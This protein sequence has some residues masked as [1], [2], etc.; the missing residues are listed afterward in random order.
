[1]QAVAAAALALTAVLLP[2]HSAAEQATRLSREERRIREYVRSQRDAEIAYL[3][4]V[5]NIASGTMN[6]TGV[7]RTGVVFRRTLDS[8]GFTTRWIAQDDVKRGGHLIA[9]HAGKRGAATILLIG[10][11]D[12]VYEGEGQAWD[13]DGRDSLAK[14]AGTSDMK[15]GDVILV[16]ALRALAQSGALKDANIIVFL[17]GDE[18]DA[19]D[20]ISASRRDLIAAA[21]RADVALSFESASEGA[22]VVARRGSSSWQLNVSAPQAHSSGIFRDSASP[23]AIYEAARILEAFR[24]GLAGIP[25]LSFNPGIFAGGTSVSF[26]ST[27]VRATVEGKT[28]IIAPRATVTGDL[29]FISEG[30]LDSA[31]AA[32][33]AIVAR[34]LT[35]TTAKIDFSD[36]YP[37]MTPTEENYRLLGQYSAVSEA[38]GYGAIAAVDPGSRGAGDISFVAPLVPA[39]LDAL[40]VSGRGAHSPNERV[41]LNSLVPQTERAAILIYRLSRRPS[42]RPARPARRR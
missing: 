42:T 3:A 19:G 37:A 14:G 21:R 12:T 32:M 41:N 23:G 17:T 36:S 10:H 25:N 20:P 13:R 27:G 16:F 24:E 40:G 5:V 6:A 29:R 15:G 39:S 31:R 1:M 4:R 8:L 22:A 7:Q 11:L 26:D 28:N 18:E 33:R 38:L 9:E 34:N 30:Q 35:R 2:L